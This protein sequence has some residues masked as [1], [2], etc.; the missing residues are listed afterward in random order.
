[1]ITR[2]PTGALAGLPSLT[3]D[4]A[5]VPLQDPMVL[6]QMTLQGLQPGLVAVRLDAAPWGD[7]DLDAALSYLASDTRTSHLVT[8]ADRPCTESSWPAM[9]VWVSLDVT[10]LLQLAGGQSVQDMVDAVNSLP[11]LPE[12]RELVLVLPKGSGWISAAHLLE[13]S[14]RLACEDC[15]L[16]VDRADLRSATHTVAK[17]SGWGVRV[18]GAD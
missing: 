17:A 18:T 1:M 15:W 8:W 12:P 6:V 2:I 10:P 4:L 9:P 14:S 13:V 3:L 16:Y 11:Y 5:G 7:Q